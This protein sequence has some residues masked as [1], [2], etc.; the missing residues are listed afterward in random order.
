MTGKRLW[1]DKNCKKYKGVSYHLAAIQNP[2]HIA[3]AI[4]LR[5]H[6][7]LKHIFYSSGRI[8]DNFQNTIYS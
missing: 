7:Y 2:V 1:Y 8:K 5:E 4:A 6:N 3:D